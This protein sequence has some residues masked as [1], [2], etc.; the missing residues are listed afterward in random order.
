MRATVHVQAGDGESVDRFITC[1]KQALK[2]CKVG[3]VFFISR[4]CH[5]S[6]CINVRVF[7]Y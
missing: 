3:I 7:M 4:H 6:P 2:F 1:F 5:C